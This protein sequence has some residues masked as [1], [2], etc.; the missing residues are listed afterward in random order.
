MHFNFF[1]FPF[2]HL[3]GSCI[4]W[5]FGINGLKIVSSQRQTLQAHAGLLVYIEKEGR[6]CIVS[7]AY[8]GYKLSK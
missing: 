4:D 2:S 6:A 7:K 8:Y 3:I 1:N 5:H